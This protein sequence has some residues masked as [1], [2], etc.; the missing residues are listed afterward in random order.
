MI[1]YAFCE[2]KQCQSVC[3]TKAEKPR[4][5]V[6]NLDWLVDVVSGEVT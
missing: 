6:A 3:Q 4:G 1:S 2:A 5:Q